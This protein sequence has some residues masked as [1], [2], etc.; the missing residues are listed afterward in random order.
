MCRRHDFT[1]LAK[2][3]E[4]PVEGQLQTLFGDAEGF[5]GKVTMLAVCY[6]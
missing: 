2:I 4:L 1:G 6:F 3:E 5:A